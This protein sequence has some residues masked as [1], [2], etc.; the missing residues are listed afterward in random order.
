MHFKSLAAAAVVATGVAAQRPNGTSV[1]DYYTTALLKNNTAE[2][3]KTLLTLVV[4]TAVIGNCMFSFSRVCETRTDDNKT[5]SPTSASRW[6]VSSPRACTTVLRSTSCHTST[7]V[8]LPPTEA[9]ASVA[10]STSSMAAVLL[11]S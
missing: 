4:N 10:L 2:N 5:P 7:E 11:L 9:A 6:M 3:Q 8:L 1:C